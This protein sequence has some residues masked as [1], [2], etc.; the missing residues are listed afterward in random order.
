MKRFH[1]PRIVVIATIITGLLSLTAIIQA[2]ATGSLAVESYAICR[3]VVAREP[4]DAG[5]SFPASVGKLYCFTKIANV[6]G[7]GR[8]T[9]VWYYG[10]TERARVALAVDSPNWRTYSSKIIQAH[11]IGGWSVD[12]LGPEGER[13]LYIPFEITR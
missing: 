4:I 3:D 6:K 13:L 2:Q 5:T 1:S 8:I 10:E 11:E 7:P 12:V 9:H